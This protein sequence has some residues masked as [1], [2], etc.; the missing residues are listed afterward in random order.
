LFKED[1]DFDLLFRKDTNSNCCRDCCFFVFGQENIKKSS[2]VSLVLVL[3]GA[4]K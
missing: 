4:A 2:S 3:Q 1:K